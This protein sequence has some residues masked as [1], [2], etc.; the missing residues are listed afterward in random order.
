MH[1][2]TKFSWQ[3]MAA[4]FFGMFGYLNIVLQ[5]LFL[6]IFSLPILQSL[7]PEPT[8][9]V[10]QKIVVIVPQ[11]TIQQPSVLAYIFIGFVVVAMIGLSLYVLLRIPLSIV[12]SSHRIVE[13]SSEAVTPL[14]AKITHAQAPKKAER[15]IKQYV[16]LSIKCILAIL[17]LLLLYIL[18]P[19]LDFHG[20]SSGIIYIV[21]G[22][23]AAISFV[24]FGT[25]YAIARF[26][27]VRMD[28][29]L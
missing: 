29:L 17:P 25:Q 13:E 19:R 11:D 2:K 10:E 18:E 21:A 28:R 15:K 4:N 16:S 7:T 8:E 22:V 27:S 24:L 1:K 12:K 3:E 5:W 9:P 20:L 26:G 6:L 23:L 14:V